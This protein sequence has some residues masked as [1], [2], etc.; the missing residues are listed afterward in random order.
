VGAFP[1]HGATL[2][3]TT[4][5]GLVIFCCRAASAAHGPAGAGG[6]AARGGAAM[7]FNSTGTVKDLK[8]LAKAAKK[9]E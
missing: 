7:H 2:P 6:L 5:Y 1:A 9:D 3:A 8:E 4:F